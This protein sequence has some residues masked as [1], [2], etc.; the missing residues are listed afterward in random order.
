MSSAQP[1]PAA[2][3]LCLFGSSGISSF[4]RTGVLNRTAEHVSLRQIVNPEVLWKIP[5]KQAM[6]KTWG[7][8]RCLWHPGMF[9]ACPHFCGNLLAQGCD[10]SPCLPP[11][12]LEFSKS[13]PPSSFC[14]LNEAIFTRLGQC[15][16]HLL[17]LRACWH[18]ACDSCLNSPEIWGLGL[19]EINYNPHWF[20]NL[21]GKRNLRISGMRA[22]FP[23][24]W[25][26]LILSRI[27]DNFL[28]FS[29]DFKMYF[30][31]LLCNW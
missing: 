12:I 13:Q 20:S 19:C 28:F 21:K 14:S 24:E 16:G 17:S 11:Q 26:L 6:R 18:W 23:K 7:E 3:A 9:L 30:S 29:P 4:G 10:V 8:V 15:R 22:I 27:F 31:C 5:K 25:I 1:W 2:E